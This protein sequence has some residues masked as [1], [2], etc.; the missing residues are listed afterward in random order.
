M[1]S[2]CPSGPTDSMHTGCSRSR[3]SQECPGIP[4]PSPR[5]CSFSPA[6][7]S[8]C[9]TVCH[10]LSVYHS[11]AHTASTNI[12]RAAPNPARTLF[13][14]LCLSAYTCHGS[15]QGTTQ[16][17]CLVAHSPAPCFPCD[18]E[19][20]H[21]RWSCDLESVCLMCLASAHGPSSQFWPDADTALA[22]LT[23]HLPRRRLSPVFPLLCSSVP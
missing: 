5:D 21:I 12:A 18:Q 16:T 19:H 9:V 14:R 11:P 17:A 8:L 7:L 15:L 20:L 23:S 3:A 13:S 10:A 6:M 1:V 2:G 22:F 4:M